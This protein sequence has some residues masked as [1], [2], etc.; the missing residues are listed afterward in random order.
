M[1]PRACS[2]CGTLIH[3]KTVKFCVSCGATLPPVGLVPQQAAGSSG[4]VRRGT[5]INDNDG[6]AGISFKATR[7]WARPD[8]APARKPSK[9][10]FF[11]A[12]FFLSIATGAL[13]I[14]GLDLQVRWDTGNYGPHDDHYDVTF[15]AGVVF[16]GGRFKNMAASAYKLWLSV[17]WEAI[18]DA[19]PDEK[20]A[21]TLLDNQIPQPCIT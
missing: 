17:Y 21:T 4:S 12:A 16:I 14:S 18:E 11:M 5:S 20:K 9:C 10:L 1:A 6:G 19:R 15:D 2:L 7:R 13:A 3:D 8:D